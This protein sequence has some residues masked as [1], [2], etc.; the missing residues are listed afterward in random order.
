MSIFDHSDDS[1]KVM[2]VDTPESL[3]TTVRNASNLFTNYFLS[4]KPVK[5]VGNALSTIGSIR[6]SNIA[7]GIKSISVKGY[8]GA[9]TVLHNLYHIS[10]AK[11]VGVFVDPIAN[12]V[13]AIRESRSLIKQMKATIKEQL[14]NIQ[15]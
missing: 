5:F 3:R 4:K 9:G 7:D 10:P 12:K 1:N 2:T 6:P 14:D 13:S 8:D 11:V 15:Q